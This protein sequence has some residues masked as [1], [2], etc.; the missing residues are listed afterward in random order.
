MSGPWSD[1]MTI[2]TSAGSPVRPSS[3][4][5]TSSDT[6]TVFA[7]ASFRTDTLMLGLPLV[8]DMDVGLPAP[9]LTF[10]TSLRRMGPNSDAPTIRFAISSTEASV[11]M[12][13]AGTACPPSKMR[14]AGMLRLFS[15]RAAETWNRD[16]PLAA[17]LCGSTATWTRRSTSPVTWICRMPGMSE[18]TGS[19][20]ACTSFAISAC[21]LSAITL[22][23]IMGSSLGL[24]RP[25]VGRP[26]P[27]GKSMLATAVA[28]SASAAA[29]SV[30]NT[31]VARIMELPSNVL[32]CTVSRPAMPDMAV[33]IGSVTSRTTASGFADG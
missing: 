15:L 2:S 13:L 22:N 5:R 17:I 24:K 30:P 31:K 25:T 11:W 23:C 1:T 26:T 14:P 19:T 18:I 28:T 33:S 7:S 32:D 8:C 12:V 4:S 21:S 29:M 3:A 27:A 10:A 20:S 16:T 6:S 9:R